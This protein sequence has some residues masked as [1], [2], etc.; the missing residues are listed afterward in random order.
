MRC[1]VSTFP[2]TTAAT[3]EGLSI[4]PGGITNFIGAKHP[5]DKKKTIQSA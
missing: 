2:P 3:S 1:E 4:V 5:C